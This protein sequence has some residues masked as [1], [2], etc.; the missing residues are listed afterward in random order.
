M[1][2]RVTP[3]PTPHHCGATSPHHMYTGRWINQADTL[4]HSGHEMSIIERVDITRPQTGDG[5]AALGI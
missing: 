3:Q 1:L 5:D 2:S 4:T